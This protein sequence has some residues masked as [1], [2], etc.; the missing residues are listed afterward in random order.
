MKGVPRASRQSDGHEN[1]PFSVQLL[2]PGISAIRAAAPSE[3]AEWVLKMPALTLQDL[4]LRPT[5][6]FLLQVPVLCWGRHGL[7]SWLPA[8][9]Q[10][11]LDN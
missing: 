10:D 9:A 11:V 6:G 5:S 4:G 2:T 3:G 7:C 8:L 1:S